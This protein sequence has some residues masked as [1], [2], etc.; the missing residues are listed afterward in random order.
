MDESFLPPRQI[1]INKFT[2]S[3]KDELTKNYYSYRCQY[4]TSCKITIKV[5]RDELEKY[6]KVNSQII[7]FEITSK[8]KNHK[9]KNANNQSKHDAKIEENNQDNIKDK[10]YK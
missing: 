6:V 10:N 8:E 5:A 9:C 2:Y 3:Y 1:I 7:K 4:R